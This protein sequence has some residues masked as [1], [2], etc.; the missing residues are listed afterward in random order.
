MVGFE[1]VSISSVEFGIK[2]N[3]KKPKFS[4]GTGPAKIRRKP[5]VVQ[6]L[7][8]EENPWANLD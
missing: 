5:K 6:D 8:A 2:I 7:P 1:F 3:G 4:K